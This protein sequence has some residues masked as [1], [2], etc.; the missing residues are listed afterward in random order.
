MAHF[1]VQKNVLFLIILGILVLIVGSIIIDSKMHN[2]SLAKK[3][4]TCTPVV[5]YVVVT[6][7]L[8]VS[9][10]SIPTIVKKSAITP[11]ITATRSATVK[12]VPTLKK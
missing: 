10:K 6:P 12:I 8:A 1:V 3:T 7:T 2:T 11:T 4:P 5:K 9:G